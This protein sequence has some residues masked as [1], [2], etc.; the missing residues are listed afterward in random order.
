MDEIQYSVSEI[1]KIYQLDKKSR[2]TLHK[3]RTKGSIPTPIEGKRGSVKTYFWNKYD[4]PKI[5]AHYG[6]L[7]PADDFVCLTFHASKGGTLK[8][9]LSYF[10]GRTLALNGIRVLMIGV[11]IQGSLTQVALNKLGAE[12]ISEIGEIEQLP[13]IYEILQNKVKIDKTIIQLDLPTL[14]LIPENPYLAEVEK[15]ISA[16]RG[17]R[18]ETLK[19]KLIKPIRNSKKFDVVIIDT[20]PSFNKLTECSLVS[21]T[22][23]G[24]VSPIGCDVGSY[25]TADATVDGIE[26]FREEMLDAKVPI[27]WETTKIVPTLLASTKLSQQIHASYVHR[28]DNVTKNSIRR[29]VKGEQDLFS[30]VTPF[31]SASNPRLTE[32][33]LGVITEIWTSCGGKVSLKGN[34]DE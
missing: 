31:E 32:D 26:T 7:K 22:N 11:D 12:D 9:C 27:E 8:T 16:G 18:E 29:T 17:S 15:M 28:Y 6:F 20:S 14:S 19:N 23:G 30:G 4:L 33:Y 3:A 25:F 10:V 34:A 21:A 5:G 13:G 24:L 1:C 2:S